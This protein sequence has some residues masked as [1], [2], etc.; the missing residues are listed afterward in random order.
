LGGLSVSSSTIILW[1]DMSFLFVHKHPASLYLK[2]KKLQK[3]LE[4]ER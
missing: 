4:P 3:L 2:I 1:F